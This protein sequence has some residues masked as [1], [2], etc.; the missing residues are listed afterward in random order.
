VPALTDAVRFRDLVE[1]VGSL[2]WKPKAP[3]FDE[4]CYLSKRMKGVALKAVAESHLV[5]F[6]SVHIGE[7]HHV[8]RAACKIDQLG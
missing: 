4:R 3:S 2:D 6:R 7:C 8:L 5:L 1:W